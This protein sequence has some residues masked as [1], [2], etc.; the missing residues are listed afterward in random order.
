M[1][2][3]YQA[4]RLSQANVWRRFWLGLGGLIKDGVSF[5]CRCRRSQQAVYA[6]QLPN[7]PLLSGGDVTVGDAGTLPPPT[8]MLCACYGGGGK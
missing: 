8:I 3:T 6:K 1:P 4:P 7:A 5:S 2:A